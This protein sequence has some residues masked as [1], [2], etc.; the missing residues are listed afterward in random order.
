MANWGALAGLGD[1]LQTLGNAWTEREKSK[2]ASQLLEQ[3]EINREARAKAREDAERL[4]KN[5]TWA[6]KSDT[7]FTSP[8]G[9]LMR[10][11]WSEGGTRLESTLPEQD[12]I[13]TWKQQEEERE[14][15]RRKS[16]ADVLTA[17]TRLKREPEDW[18]LKRRAAEARIG[19]SNA[20]AEASRARATTSLDRNLSPPSPSIEDLADTLIDESEGFIEQYDLSAA[21]ARA[22]ALQAIRD[23]RASGQNPKTLFRDML[24]RFKDLRNKSKEKKKTKTT[25][26]LGLT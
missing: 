10:Q 8:D 12:Q 11:K 17:E 14:L 4:R 26:T 22:A 6:P 25:G 18:E 21:E 9:V 23:G 7:L 20:S 13:Q 3:R 15:A 24:P 2:L 19:A 16:L 5:S 1:G